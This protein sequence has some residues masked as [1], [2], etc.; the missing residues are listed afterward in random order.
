MTIKLMF[1][2]GERP[3]ALLQSG[4]SRVGS[5][6][7]AEVLLEQEGMPAVLCDLRVS[8]DGV[9]LN[10]PVQDGAPT[11]SVNGKPVD[12]FIAVRPGDQIRFGSV[13]VKTTSVAVAN[14]V[15]ASDDPD[16]DPGATR[17]RTAVP[18]Y[19]LRGVSGAVFSKS[20]AIT[21]PMVFGRS[22]EC[23]VILDSD[24][25][26]RKH[27]EVRPTADGL[28]VEDLDSANGTFINGE[29][30]QKAL[31]KGGDELRLDTIRLTLVAPDG[32]SPLESVS[33]NTADRLAEEQVKKS[34]S[35][36]W[37]VLGLVLIAVAI[38]LAMMFLK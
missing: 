9:A 29:R 4:V 30:V 10:V 8:D 7:T 36:L 14:S 27:A 12:G 2:N 25:V 15:A 17:A 35:M 16:N 13:L 6:A 18:K 34:G 32:A 24:S 33:R 20:F 38:G 19:V 31:L 21:G 28:V 1:P 5:D 37:V 11:V 26:S 3:D 23:D 22:D